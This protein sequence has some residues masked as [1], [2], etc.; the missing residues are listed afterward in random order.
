MKCPHFGMKTINKLAIFSIACLLV[1]A[2]PTLA[3]AK[4]KKKGGQP[5][6][7]NGYVVTS[8]SEGSVTI[9]DHDDHTE[10]T[11]AISQTASFNINGVDHK[12]GADLKKGMKATNITLDTSHTTIFGGHFSSK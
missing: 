5:K 8:V 9:E 2:M 11:Y 10:N 4:A 7:N 3:L 6:K 1:L 12:T